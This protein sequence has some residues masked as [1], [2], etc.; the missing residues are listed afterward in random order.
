MKRIILAST[1]PRRKELLSKAGIIFET[2]ASDY[3]EDMVLPLPP[4]QLAMHLAQG[5]A[6]SVARKTHGAIVISA[7]TFI[8]LDTQVLGKPKTIQRAREM[9]HAMN[10]RAHV[11]L[12]GYAVIDTDSKKIVTG[13]AETH[14]YFKQLSEEE[15]E[16]Y[17]ANSDALDCAGAY[18]MQDETSHLLIDRFEGSFENA[19]G[20]PLEEILATLEQFSL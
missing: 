6:E 4:S 5:K 7:D 13:S 10:G 11:I 3:E 16:T 14:V 17:L 19:I 8:V 20:F 9:I 1:S 2:I 18:A 15:I 12:T